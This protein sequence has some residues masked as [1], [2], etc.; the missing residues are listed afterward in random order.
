MQR[1]HYEGYSFIESFQGGSLLG[2][3]E[4]TNYPFRVRI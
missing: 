1:P 4:A 3:S 2:V